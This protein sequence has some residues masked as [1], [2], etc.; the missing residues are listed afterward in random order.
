MP[1][2]RK[3]RFALS[4]LLVVFLYG[5]SVFIRAELREREAEDF[6]SEA[7][8]SFARPWNATNLEH[9]SS[10]WLKEKSNLKPADIVK[11]AQSDYGNL[12]DLTARPSC[13]LNRGF[14]KYSTIEHTY[15]ICELQ[16]KM[17][18]REMLIMKIRIIQ[19]DGA[20]RVNDFMSVNS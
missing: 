20:W 11:M 1:I 17:E 5:A 16:L 8:L 15:A 14:D 2:A 18:K 13:V 12:I 9:N 3:K 19:E 4:G 7:M 10:W 6:A